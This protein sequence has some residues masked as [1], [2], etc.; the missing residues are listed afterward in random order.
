MGKFRFSLEHLL[1]HRTDIEQRESDALL[2][3][4]YSYQVALRDK[5]ILEQKLTETAR[6]LVE[7]Q[8]DKTLP[9]EI[10]WFYSYMNRLH[11]EIDECEK[12]LAKLD[13]EI[14]VQ[15]E[16]VVEAAKNRKV[17]SKL[18]SKKEKEFVKALDKKEQKEVEEWVAAKYAVERQFY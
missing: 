17:L 11:Y 2:R 9:Q 5:D 15:K 1:K 6:D 10:A 14:Q 18:K 8:A 13:S 12:K 7:E 4:K 3:I 16:I